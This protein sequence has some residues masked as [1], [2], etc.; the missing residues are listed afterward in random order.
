[1]ST[2]TVRLHRVLRANPE[3]IYRAFLDADAM[4]KWLPSYAFT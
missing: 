1:M 3:R 4:T 2:G